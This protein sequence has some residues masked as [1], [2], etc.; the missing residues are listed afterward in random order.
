MKIKKLTIL[1]I[2]FICLALG[3]G[4]I[5]MSY[6][7][8]GVVVH[9][10]DEGET[11][12]GHA[13]DISRDTFIASYTSYVG[14]LGGVYIFERQKKSWEV[15]NHFPSP[16]NKARDWFGWN[17]AI[18]GDTALVG[19]YEEGGKKVVAG[20]PL[21]EGPGSV[22]VYERAGKDFGKA[23][24]LRGDDSADNDRFGYSVDISGDT[25]VV[26]APFDDDADSSSGSVYVFV[27]D[28]AKWKQQA[29]LTADDAAKNARFGWY[30]A[31]AGDTVV[32]GAPLAAAPE[33][34]SGAA[35]IFTRVGD[36]WTQQ[37]KLVA[38]DGDSNDAF[39]TSVAISSD[40]VLIGAPKDEETGRNSGSA[41]IFTRVGDV[42]TQQKKLT[43]SDPEEGASFGHSVSIHE[44]RAIVGAPFRDGIDQDAGAAYTFLRAGANWVEQGKLEPQ[45]LK[46]G[47]QEDLTSGDNFGSAIAI[48]GSFGRNESFAA[49]GSRWD[50]VAA[51]NDRGSVYIYDTALD[52]GIRL[53]VEPSSELL[54]TTLGQ[55]KRTALFQNFP[56]PFNPETWLPYMI[57]ADAPVAIRIYDTQGKLVRQLDIGTQKA[58]VY[59]SRETA[60][61]WDGK[62]QLGEAVSSGIY[63]Y[64]LM[65]GDFQGTRRMV[66]LK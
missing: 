53:P 32:V 11:N 41:Y 20:G 65:T 33:R 10:P 55:V 14:D 59:L 19:A 12:F 37:A 30:T 13:V 45:K 35:Y 40:E 34:N 39:G 48:D 47:E 23:K 1:V 4:Q 3:I 15:I 60:A 5:T 26:G 38:A 16:D 7:G 56:N 9:R 61:Y 28:G 8:D 66:I 46:K 50:N 52:L 21:G 62:D 22:Y 57:A 6:A 64:T 63:F 44:N 31:I 2:S 54:I 49:I 27:R 18:D 17:V 42:W 36:V 25:F 43:A 58:G 24:K 29:K 51:E